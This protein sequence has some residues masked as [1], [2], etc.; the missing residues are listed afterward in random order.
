MGQPTLKVALTFLR[1]VMFSCGQYHPNRSLKWNSS[2]NKIEW[3]KHLYRTES[4]CPAGRLRYWRLPIGPPP[5]PTKKSKARPGILLGLIAYLNCSSKLLFPFPLPESPATVMA[6][7]RKCW[8]NVEKVGER[9]APVPVNK[10][11]KKIKIIHWNE[12]K[13]GSF[14]LIFLNC[15]FPQ[16]NKFAWIQFHRNP[17]PI[18]LR[19]LLHHQHFFP[20]PKVAFL[21]E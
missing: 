12:F 2:M 20:S 1:T 8:P 11:L 5:P 16:I 18:P 21:V 6:G 7:G 17:P 14:F 9:V 4:R 15:F 19:P 13:G 3:F 10:L